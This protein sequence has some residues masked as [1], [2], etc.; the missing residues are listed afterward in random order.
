LK[1]EKKIEKK[2]EMIKIFY[3]EKETILKKIM[4]AGLLTIFL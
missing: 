4:F 1:N 2:T 3:G